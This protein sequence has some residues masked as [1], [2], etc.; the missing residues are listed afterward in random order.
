ME[1]QRVTD[2]D[3]GSSATRGFRMDYPEDRHD[4]LRLVGSCPRCHDRIVKPLD[5]P[6]PPVRFARLTKRRPETVVK[7]LFFQCGCIQRYQ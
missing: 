4:H 1:W 3:W 7:T 6:W 2:W 5:P